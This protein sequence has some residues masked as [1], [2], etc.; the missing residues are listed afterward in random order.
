M[1]V[2]RCNAGVEIGFG[3]LMRCRVLAEALCEQGQQCVMVGPDSR[4]MTDEDKHIFVEWINLAN[5]TSPEKDANHLTE[6]MH[7]YGATWAILDD[8][9]VDDN[10]QLKLRDSGMHWLQ[11]AHWQPQKYWSDIVLTPSPAANQYDWAALVKNPDAKL[12]LGPKYAILR[13]E[14]RDIQ[15]RDPVR[16]IK[17]VLVTF[18]GGDDRGAIKFVLNTLI[19]NTPNEIEFVVLSGANNPSNT[20]LQELS[21]INKQNRVHLH[22][23]PK[24]VAPLFLSCDLAIIAGGTTTYEAA[25][26]GLPMILI[27]IADNQINQCIGWQNLGAAIYLGPF[28]QVLLGNL[29][30]TAVSNLL[31]HPSQFLTIAESSSNQVNSNGIKHIMKLLL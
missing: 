9:R 24:S 30:T 11:F 1:I 12:L 25:C 26:C 8:Y 27:S 19:P 21:Q 18:G 7:R 23:A 28:P 2:F 31:S 13:S 4:L 22:I 5:W 10:Y 20:Q 15:P 17:R 29:L 14:F 16:P 6:I 3:H